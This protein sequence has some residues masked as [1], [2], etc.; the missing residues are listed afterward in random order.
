MQKHP[1]SAAAAL[2]MQ[3]QYAASAHSKQHDIAAATTCM[4]QHSTDAYKS[5]SNLQ[6]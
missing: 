5:H 1:Q 2:N 6:Q 4:L 3:Q